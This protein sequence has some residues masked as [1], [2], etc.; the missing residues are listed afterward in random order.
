M[1]RKNWPD[2]PLSRRRSVRCPWRP[3]G[4]MLP[5]M[6]ARK[7]LRAAGLPLTVLLIAAHATNDSFGSMLAAMLPTLQLRFGASETMLALF[8]ATH[9]FSSSVTQ[10]LFGAVADRIGR[11]TSVAAGVITSSVVLSLM[12]VAPSPWLLLLLLL[13]G[14][15]GSAAFH[16]AGTGIA[17]ET[18]GGNKGLALGL[19]SAGGTL[20]IAVGPLVIGVFII[21]GWL[22][23]TPL[24]M[25]PGLILG[26][27]LYLLL[28]ASFDARDPGRPHAKLFDL[29]L[30]LGPIGLLTLAGILRSIS[31]VGFN[32]AAPLWLVHAR[33]LANDDPTVFWT[34]ATFGVAGGVG[35]IAAGLLEGRIG[36]QALVSGTMLLAL[37]P[38]LTLM[39][40]TPGTPLYFVLVFLA[41]AFI[42]GGLPLMV[43]SAQDLAPHAVGTASGMMMG[44]TWG[45]AGVL[46]LGIG[47]LQQ[48]LGITPAMI[49]GFSTLLPGAVVSW[50]VLKRN[51]VALGI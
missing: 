28:P 14:G 21:N 7:S 23:W 22:T 35:G 9:S 20:G 47:A 51:R 27:L 18:A 26:A 10:P 5:A 39:V 31:W 50:Y 49:I 45:T 15:L 37:V 6:T 36:R 29:E 48:T 12:G 13:L 24:L 19:F 43:V 34:L 8:V 30:F 16:P 25:V 33:G 44:L 46:Y 1:P 17:R 2:L 32:S 3:R 4:V 40:T 42:N 11:R 41:G 38:L